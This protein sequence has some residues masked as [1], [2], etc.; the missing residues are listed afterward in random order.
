M[1]PSNNSALS[2]LKALISSFNIEHIYYKNLAN[3]EY[4]LGLAICV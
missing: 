4:P 2:C 3:L 1:V